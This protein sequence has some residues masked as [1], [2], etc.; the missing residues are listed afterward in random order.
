ME[1]VVV[2]LS[3]SIFLSIFSLFWPPNPAPRLFG[4]VWDANLIVV[5]SCAFRDIRLKQSIEFTSLLVVRLYFPF[6]FNRFCLGSDPFLLK[7]WRCLAVF[8]QHQI[9]LELFLL[10]QV[11]FK[12]IV[13]ILHLFLDGRFLPILN[14]YIDDWYGAALILHW[15]I[16]LWLIIRIIKLFFTAY[17]TVILAVFLVI[18]IIIVI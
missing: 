13:L 9:L 12:Q 15:V 16:R 17:L 6:F 3:L 2:S 7:S 8:L 4:P 1:S 14:L 18:F 11:F 5:V 10:L